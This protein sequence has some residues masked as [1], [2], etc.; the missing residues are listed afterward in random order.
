MREGR[1]LEVSKHSF[2]LKNKKD[3]KYIVFFNDLN[4]TPLSKILILTST[5]SSLTAS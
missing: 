5:T 1:V 3:D 4:Y 2:A